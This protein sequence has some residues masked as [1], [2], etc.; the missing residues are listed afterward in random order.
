MSAGFVAVVGTVNHDEIV[1]A[2]ARRIES[3]GG[4]LYNAIPLA[5]LLEGSGIHVRV[6]ARLGAEDRETAGR[7]LSAFPGADPRGL[8]ADP[9]GTNRSFLD[10]SGPGDRVER[11]E[12]RVSPLSKRDLGEVVDARL[13]LV[14]MISGRDVSQETIAD[15]KRDSA[16]PFFLDVQAL[17]RTLESPRRAQT[18]PDWREWCRVFE[19][20]R[21]NE[22]EI[23]HFAGVP[24]DTRRAMVR[25]LDA[26]AQEV[27][28]T[29]GEHGSLRASREEEE[30]RIEEI[31]PYACEKQGDV[32][33]CGD[34]YLA[35]IC[36]G[37]VLGLAFGAAARLGSW[38]AAQVGSLTGLESMVALRGLRERALS[39][40][41]ELRSPR[42]DS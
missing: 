10:Y 33:G 27:L 19:V 39:L 20:I 13:V 15:L 31:P 2:D 14:N 24:G 3:L 5:A 25:I 21:G 12:F 42:A 36:A 37:R 32:T 35:G 4:I 11:V 29:R 1:T 26:G 23:S 16:G 9:R 8:I 30:P 22:E 38:T 28:A 6:Y 34:S 40:F 7:L 18:V 41:P 17:T